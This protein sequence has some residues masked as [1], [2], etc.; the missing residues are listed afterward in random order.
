MGPSAGHVFQERRDRKQHARKISDDLRSRIESQ[1]DGVLAGVNGLMTRLG[2][3][4]VTYPFTAEAIESIDRQ[5]RADIVKG[6]D[7]HNS[8]STE[9]KAAHLARLYS[10][11]DWAVTMHTN[12]IRANHEREAQGLPIRHPQ[13]EI[14]AEKAKALKGRER[15][16]KAIFALKKE[17]RQGM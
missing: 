4:E 13:E 17:F 8:L 1:C 14:E 15:I 12:M 11:I 6:H 3:A 16:Q 9:D 2:L 10:S 5:T 7:A